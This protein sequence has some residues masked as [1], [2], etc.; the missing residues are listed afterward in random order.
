[1]PKHGPAY[2]PT[3]HPKKMTLR[4]EDVEKLSRRYHT[5]ADASAA[6]GIN[7]TTYS[8]LCREFGVPL[9]RDSQVRQKLPPAEAQEAPTL[10]RWCDLGKLRTLLKQMGMT[11]EVEYHRPRTQHTITLTEESD[12]RVSGR[13][14]FV[15]GHRGEFL[16]LHN[17][18]PEC[19]HHTT[20]IT[21]GV[22]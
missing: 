7:K 15:F 11:V 3:T 10:S 18:D 21:G 1:M 4:K 20:Q 14:V 9:P 16:G 12:F 8:R 5:T 19:Q 22:Q 2:I 17:S 13:T 6:A